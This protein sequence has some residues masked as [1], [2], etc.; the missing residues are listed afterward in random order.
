[1]AFFDYALKTI[2]ESPYIGYGYGIGPRYKMLAEMDLMRIS[3]LHNAWI[4]V[5]IGTGFIGLLFILISI[6]ISVKNVFIASLRKNKLQKFNIEYLGVVL[7]M[8]IRSLASS[9][10]VLH[11]GFLGL[12]TLVV[13]S[14]ILKKNSNIL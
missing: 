4:E 8:L 14:Y 2:P 12:V 13:Y 10:I 5:L 7:S 6:I 3:S 9:G 1:M 11:P